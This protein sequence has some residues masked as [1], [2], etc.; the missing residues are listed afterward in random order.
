ML[1][2]IGLGIENDI[3]LKA[4]DAI[5]KC[6]KLYL[7]KYT[8]VGCSTTELEK[9]FKKK[10]IEIDREFMESGEEILKN[11]KD[12]NI[13]V[14]IYGDVFFAT[15][16]LSL[17]LDAYKEKIKVEIIHG[18]SV[19]NFLGD[20]G[21]SMYNFGKIG[22]ISFNEKDT[23]FNVLKENKDMHTLFLLDL[24]PKNG[25]FLS[26]NDALKYLLDK[27]MMNRLVV[28]CSKLG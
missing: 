3:S 19:F 27:G 8:S 22:S 28:G 15:T 12:N 25:N 4:L 1:Y 26:I 17:L 18:V 7:E 14:L 16:H 13:G 20:I 24:D 11:S 21:L 6:D 9:L 2:L 10:I 23:A 5:K